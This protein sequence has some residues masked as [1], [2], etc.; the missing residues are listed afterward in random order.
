[1]ASPR[2]YVYGGR[3][4]L[5]IIPSPMKLLKSTLNAQ[6]AP[7]DDVDRILRGEKPADLRAGAAEKV[8][9]LKISSAA[10]SNVN[11][12]RLEEIFG[13]RTPVGASACLPK[14]EGSPQRCLATAA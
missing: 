8:Q 6:P 10:G 1:M 9:S 3:P 13:K 11:G 7:G 5:R 12:R 2:T 4:T 14:A